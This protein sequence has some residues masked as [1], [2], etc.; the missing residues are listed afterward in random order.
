MQLKPYR[1]FGYV[2]YKN[3]WTSGEPYVA[4]YPEGRK[5][6][7]LF[8]EGQMIN[9]TFADGTTLPDYRASWNVQP[10]ASK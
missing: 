2:I 5:W 7:N 4:T 10:N 8:T 6:H 1:A 3:S 9:N